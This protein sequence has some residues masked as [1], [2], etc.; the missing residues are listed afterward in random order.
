MSDNIKRKLKEKFLG[1]KVLSDDSPPQ[2]KKTRKKSKKAR[3][4]CDT[5]N[6]NILENEMRNMYMFHDT[7]HQL[8]AK[9]YC[10]EHV[11]KYHDHKCRPSWCGDCGYLI[12]YEIEI[13]K[14]K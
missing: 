2:K 14:R 8:R 9:E 4:I 11:T 12:K 13:Q 3:T 7:Y 6:Q 1:E 5:C 10:K